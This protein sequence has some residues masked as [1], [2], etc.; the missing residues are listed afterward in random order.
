VKNFLNQFGTA[1]LGLALRQARLGFRSSTVIATVPSLTITAIASY[2]IGSVAAMKII[3]IGVRARKVI[4][5]FY[6]DRR[7]WLVLIIGD[8]W[9]RVVGRRPG[10]DISLPGRFVI[11]FLGIAISGWRHGHIGGVSKATSRAANRN[12]AQEA[13]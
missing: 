7:R 2:H 4:V 1:C 13:K 6:H 12:C 8:W 9:R 3:P 10:V 5:R 11:V